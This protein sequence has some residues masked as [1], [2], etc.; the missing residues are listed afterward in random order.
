MVRRGYRI[1]AADRFAL[2]DSATA[3]LGADLRLAAPAGSVAD[4][5][6]FSPFAYRLYEEGLQLYYRDDAA[7]ASRFFQA[8]LRE[9]STFAMANYY[10]WISANPSGIDSVGDRAYRLASK[11]PE[12]DRLIIMTVVEWHRG[13]PFALVHADSLAAR[14]PNDPEA[15]IAAARVWT[16][17][18]MTNG[19]AP[20]LINRVIALDSSAGATRTGICRLCY[21]FSLLASHFSWNDSLT[22]L[23]ETV[24]R[25]KRLVPGDPH[26]WSVQATIAL[27]TGGLEAAAA[28]TRVEDSLRPT[29]VERTPEDL[30]RW[31]LAAGDLDD[32]ERLCGAGS[33]VGTNRGSLRWVC[34]ILLRY[35][36]RYREANRL[37]I[38]GIWA[39]KP[40]Y[41]GLPPDQISRAT[42]DLETRRGHLA[43]QE[44]LEIAK[45]WRTYPVPGIA[46]RNVAWNLTLAATAMAAS[47]E[48]IQAAALADT[49]EDVG[50]RSLYG[51]DPRLHFFIRGLLKAARGD[52]LGAVALY[53]KAAFSWTFGYTRINYELAR[54][55]L[56]LHRPEDAIRPL[57]AALRGGIDGSN[58][59]LSRTEVH[60]LLGRAFAEAGQPDSAAAHYGQVVRAWAKADPEFR[61]RYQEALRHATPATVKSD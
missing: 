2:V 20:A 4:I 57:Q 3:A 58:T 1:V 61:A 28:A 13:D 54:S 7:G 51:R 32:A 14:F 11:A 19:R 40:S 6:T 45:P 39:N 15:L 17:A 26:V 56:A 49:I 10:A 29:A 35:Q 21:A 43:A 16:F 30:V 60:E 46:A 48:W 47:G 25:W 33:R 18:S 59:Y 12:R 53:E 27:N 34:T 52:H 44:F 55:L 36:G 50:K 5:S 38:A 22:G 37:V 9:D 41:A 31:S 24:R 23:D 42:L 8:A